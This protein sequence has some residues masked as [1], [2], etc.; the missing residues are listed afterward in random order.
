MP[1]AK[2]LSR[3]LLA[4]LAKVEQ[5]AKSVEEQRVALTSRS[6][7]MNIRIRQLHSLLVPV[8]MGLPVDA[9]VESTYDNPPWRYQ[10]RS[11]RLYNVP[12]IE[13]WSL[14]DEPSVTAVMDDEPL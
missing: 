10:L 3:H 4:E 8:F 14:P 11:G 2:K 1:E 6:D 12:K 5:E 9:V 7:E 13:V